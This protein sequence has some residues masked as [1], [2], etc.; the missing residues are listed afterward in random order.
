MS[1]SARDKQILSE[2]ECRL[3]AGEPRLAR[4]LETG[5][6]PVLGRRVL[7]ASAG[8]WSGALTWTSLLIVA[9]LLIGIAALTS[10]LALGIRVLAGAGI[11][12]AQ[13]GPVCVGLACRRIR[14]SRQ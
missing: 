4:A 12:I 5:R 7:A 13:L 11:V 10:G 1:L 3:S 9:V 14:A 8:S 2:I 6:L